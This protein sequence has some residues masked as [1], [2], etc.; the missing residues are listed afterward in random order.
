MKRPR[1]P[2]PP[3]P[4]VLLSVDFDFFCRED[5]AWAFDHGYTDHY[6]H[7]AWVQRERAFRDRGLDLRDETSLRHAS[8]HPDAFW[9][10]L[11]GLGYR[12][13]QLRRIVIADSHEHA[14]GA[15]G[16]EALDGRGAD[17]VLLVNIDAHHDLFYSVAQLEWSAAEDAPTCE[18]WHFFTLMRHKGLRSLVVYPRWRGLREWDRTMGQLY[19]SK[20]R[21]GRALTRAFQKRTAP[22]IWGDPAVAGAAAAV[23][24][25]FIAKSSAWVPPWHDEVFLRFCVA[26]MERFTSA[27][28]SI[29]NDDGNPLAGRVMAEAA[30]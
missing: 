13:D 2:A 1:V 22:C 27:T 24:T 30:A 21:N 26:A 3:R 6:T 9:A 12:F 7:E 25:L 5:E 8:P 18:N 11:E 4:L 14:Y 17:E 16:H 20:D 28:I 29:I 23:G 15:F 10:E 19:R